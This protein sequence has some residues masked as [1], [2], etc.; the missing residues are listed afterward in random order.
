MADDENLQFDTAETTPGEPSSKG[1]CARCQKAITTVYYEALGQVFCSSCKHELE[2]Q[3]VSGFK[4]SVFTRAT[5]FG[6]VGA[7]GGALLYFAV[8]A[9]TGYEIGL[10]A[11]VVG[12]MVGFMVRLGARSRGGR[13]YQVLA[14][15]LTYLAIG[16]TYTGLGLK[17]MFDDDASPTATDSTAVTDTVPEPEPAI[18]EAASDTT[19]PG[20]AQS[21]GLLA[22]AALLALMAAMPVLAVF[23]SLPG[24]LISGLIIGFA[25]RQSW[26]MNKAISVDFKGPFKVAPA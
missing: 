13:S 7:L 11:I 14:L 18:A 10:I 6:A 24:S 22:L 3:L 8:V 19:A 21:V 5:V 12:F 16:S 25:L 17:Q 20:G 4:G 23:G 26:I 9:L 2:A 1:V 15:T